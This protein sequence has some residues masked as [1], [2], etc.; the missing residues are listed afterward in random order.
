MLAPMPASRTPPATRPVSAVTRLARFGGEVVVHAT[1]AFV[2][3]W[4]VV[5]AQMGAGDDPALGAGTATAHVRSGATGTSGG[6]AATGSDDASSSAQTTTDADPQS[7][8]GSGAGAADGSSL[9]T[10]QS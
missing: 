9:V 4:G 7:A 5:Y 8:T 1:G 3:A 10:G 6:Q 2:A